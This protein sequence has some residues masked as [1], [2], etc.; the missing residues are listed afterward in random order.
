MLLAMKIFNSA[1]PEKDVPLKGHYDQLLTGV[2]KDLERQKDQTTR[3]QQELSAQREQ[4]K[5]LF[6]HPD[7]FHSLVNHF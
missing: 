2:Q 1:G 5:G 3:T 6:T 7:Y 4:V